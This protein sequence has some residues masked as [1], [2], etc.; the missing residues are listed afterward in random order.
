VHD[1]EWAHYK[2]LADPPPHRG[3]SPKWSPPLYRGIVPAKNILRRDFAINGAVASTF[4]DFSADV[5]VDLQ[6]NS[7]AVHLRT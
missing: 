6:P 4:L 1:D 2:T 5:D 3:D 7:D